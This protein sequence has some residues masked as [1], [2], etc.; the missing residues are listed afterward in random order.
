MT[1]IPTLNQPLASLS[2]QD[3]LAF[4]DAASTLIN[5]AQSESELQE[6]KVTLQG[7]KSDITTL[8]KQMGSLDADGKKTYGAYLHELRT[9]LTTAFEARGTALAEQALNAKLA[10]SWCGIR[11]L[12]SDHA[13]HRAHEAILH[14]GGL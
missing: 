10:S 7:K 12:A 3:F 8:S 9:R 5:N 14:T 6:L 1:T 2:E 13:R 4:A 11:R